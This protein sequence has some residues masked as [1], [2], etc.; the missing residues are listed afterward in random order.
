VVVEGPSCAGEDRRGGGGG[1]RR[2]VAAGDR[3]LCR[4]GLR[5][6]GLA[7]W[8][9]LSGAGEIGL[10]NL[11]GPSFEPLSGGADDDDEDQ[12]EEDF[13]YD[14]VEEDDEKLDAEADNDEME[15]DADDT[16]K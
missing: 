1:E 5:R 12:D 4:P 13:D 10:P 15:D 9:G 14:N 2:Q 6:G 7:G 16:E 8:V 3:G 11:D